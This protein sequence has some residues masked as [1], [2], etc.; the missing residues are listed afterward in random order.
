MCIEMA[1]N[2]HNDEDANN[3]DTEQITELQIIT[4]NTEKWSHFIHLFLSNAQYQ[5]GINGL[6]CSFLI[7]HIAA[8]ICFY[9]EMENKSKQNKKW[10]IFSESILRNIW[11]WSLQFLHFIMHLNINGQFYFIY[12]FFSKKEKK[13]HYIL[14]VYRHLF[15]VKWIILVMN[16]Q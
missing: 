6:C 12:F 11:V 1:A 5:L 2:D 16:L 14:P 15:I 13:K 8:R 10:T 9:F 7:L 4:N 3:A